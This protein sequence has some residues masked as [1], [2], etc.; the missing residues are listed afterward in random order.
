MTK[1]NPTRRT[2]L[3]TLFLSAGAIVAAPLLKI[4]GALAAAVDTAKDPLA[5]ALKYF[6]VEKAEKDSKV[7]DEKGKETAIATAAKDL[8]K[9]RAD[10]AKTAKADLKKAFCSSCNFYQ[11]DAKAKLGKCTLISSGEVAS[12]GWCTSWSLKQTPKKA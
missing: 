4:Q 3:K 9:A 1:M 10:A 11:G 12:T 6:D 7:K 8:L 2:F 5:K